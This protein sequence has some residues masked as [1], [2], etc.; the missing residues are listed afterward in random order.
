MGKP[1]S[2]RKPKSVDV[3]LTDFDR[4]EIGELELVERLEL[5]EDAIEDWARLGIISSG[6]YQILI[7]EISKMIAEAMES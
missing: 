5:F 3:E 6:E 4:L 1:P 7:S 2:K